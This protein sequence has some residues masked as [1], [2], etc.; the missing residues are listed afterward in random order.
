VLVER[1]EHWPR[2]SRSSSPPVSHPRPGDPFRQVPRSVW[3]S[4]DPLTRR[5][6]AEALAPPSALGP[7]VLAARRCGAAAVPVG[8]DEVEQT[9]SDS[10]HARVEAVKV[11]DREVWVRSAAPTSA[12][13][14]FLPAHLVG[15]E[16]RR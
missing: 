16:T 8:F 11:G 15:G 12:T 4:L 1:T 2:G 9:P 7:T 13:C 10:G 14:D 3:P 5:S 6:P